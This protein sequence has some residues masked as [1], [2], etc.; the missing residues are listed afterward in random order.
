MYAIYKQTRTLCV[1]QYLNTSDTGFG[2]CH[3]HTSHNYTV[4]ML[5]TWSQREI[6]T[7]LPQ[8]CQYIEKGLKDFVCLIGLTTY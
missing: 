3:I 1:L 2:L 8:R 7:T 5:A 4:N 6:A